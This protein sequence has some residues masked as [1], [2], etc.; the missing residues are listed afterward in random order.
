[1]AVTEHHPLAKAL[2]RL[3]AVSPLTL[4]FREYDAN[5]RY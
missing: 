3:A 1:M 2:G 5:D 4:L